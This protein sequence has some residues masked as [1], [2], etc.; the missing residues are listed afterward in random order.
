M[1][2]QATYQHAYNIVEYRIKTLMA[3]DKG[4]KL[5]I[6]AKAIPDDDEMSFDEWMYDLEVDSIGW[7]DLN[8]EGRNY[9]DINTMSKV[10]DLSTA[11]DVGKL[12]EWSAH[13]KLQAGNSI[14]VTEALKG[15]AGPD[16]SLGNN[17]QNLVQTSHVLYPLYTQHN[18]VKRVVL[19]ALLT[20]AKIAWHG[21]GK[22]KLT[23]ILDDLT[24]RLLNI[25]MALVDS[26]Q[27]GLFIENSTESAEN[28]QLITSLADRALASK[29]VEL[30]DILTVLNHD[31]TAEAEAALKGAEVK[32][33][34]EDAAQEKQAQE[35]QQKMQQAQFAQD[36]KKHQ[37]EIELIITKEEEKRKT[38]VIQSSIMAA[39]FN[40][41]EDKDGDGV[42]DFIELARDGVNADIRAKEHI[43]QRDKFEHDKE[44]DKE[45]VKIEKKKVDK[46]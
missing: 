16:Q 18:G 15:Q 31:S 11:A 26:S 5:F 10:L 20:M 45:K 6:D 7:L 24:E 22:K 28:K 17:Q 9:A 36:E 30:S 37:Q 14:G 21:S 19:D 46:K 42:N 34:E 33:K 13:I 27:Y 23:Y 12:R 25:D 35:H 38:V 2:R 8:S 4:K 29:N 41:D 43:L 44:I 32:S 39:S 1:D 40:P 3:Q